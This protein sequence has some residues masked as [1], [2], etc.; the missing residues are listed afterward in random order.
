MKK[1]LSTLFIVFSFFAYAQV[2]LSVSAIEVDQPVTITIDANSTDS[3]CNGLNNP[4]KVYMHSGIG[5]NSDAFGYGVVGNWGFD[6]G[7]GEMTNN[8]DGT[9][10]ITITPQTYYGIT[11]A[12]ADTASQIGMVFRNEDGSQ[13]LKDDG[14]EDFIFPVGK[15]II[16]I[17]QP[18][19]E[20]V[21]LN[22][23]ND[24][25]LSATITF[26]GST[27]VQGS[28]EIFYNNV[29]VATGNCGFPACNATLTNVTESG[30]VKFV[31]TPPGSTETGEASFDV[32]VVPAVVEQALPANMIDGINYHTDPSK[33]TLVLTA[34]GK[35]FIQV[36]GS[37]NNYSPSASD[38]MKRDPSTG[39]YW[40]ELSGLTPGAIETYQYW[41]F[42]TNPVANSPSIVKVADP[43]SSLVL[44]P[45]DD[46]YIPASTYPNMPAYP[47]GQE[48]EVTVL[49]TGQTPYD[50]QVTDFEK[51][52]EEDLVIYEVLIRDF[53]A[54]RNFQDIIDK[55]D[56]FKNL[57]INAIELMPIMEFEGNESWGYNTAF[58][59]AI[60][61][62]YGTPEKFKELVD[63]CHQNGIAVI[64]DIAF[65]HAYGRN[66]MVRMWMDDPDGDGWGGPSSD[67]PYFNAF[68]MH[69]YSV[70][71]DF[72]HSSD[73]TRDYVKQVVSYWIEEYNIDGFRWDLTKGFTQNCGNGTLSG[74]EGCTGGYQQ[75]RVDVLKEYA[76]HSWSVDPDHYVIFEHL[77]SDNEEKEW[78]NYRLDEGKGIMMWGIMN[79][80]YGELTMGEDGNKNI[81]RMGHKAHGGFNGPRVV[82]YA[83]SHD[84]ERLMYKNIALGNT[85]NGS[86]N[87]Q[88]LNTALS[89]MSAL[90]AV[91]VMVPGPKMIWHFGELGME[92]SI[93][94]CPD[95][96]IENDGCKLATKPQP[97]WDNEWLTDALRGQI[98][99]DWSKLHKLKIEEPVFK[100]DYTITSG[101]LT[102]RIDIF[103]N[104]M[105]S[106]ELKNVI[107]LA[108]FD[109]VTR[110]IDTYF[111][112]GV[113]TTWYD[114][115]DAT[116]NTTVSN[117]TSAITIPA[118][119]FRILGNT[120]SEV[121]SV[122]DETM[123]GFS[124]YPN[125]SQSALSINVNVSNVEIYDLTGKLVKSFKGA[126]TRTDAFDIS[127]LNSGIYMVKV[128]NDTNQTLTSKLVKL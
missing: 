12:Q 65:N 124:I 60:D 91:S 18:T 63:I 42:D 114:L 31:G 13:E 117:S 101:N 53:D 27:T 88:D 15:V 85:S 82:G 72:N 28:F 93:F 34:P 95:G 109:V 10:S 19:N 45:F 62:F 84:E 81:D 86:H 54:D 69:S 9:F 17:T 73:Y 94:T 47:A 123:L 104:S 68:P 79:S 56:Y 37:W 64:L 6:D 92:N 59:M 111:P 110:S 113:T 90:G 97:Q 76:D 36:A 106:S 16:N 22:S 57:N 122:K 108:N 119:Q 52:V 125:P 74:D 29:S 23:G 100:G 33:A 71:N 30:T 14:C 46:A 50:W 112:A 41:V 75:D 89:R 51:P 44:S 98:Y 96:S 7:V 48:R 43:Y 21:V 40:L 24:L 55:I 102:P 128:Q 127:S 2:S 83:E 8:G 5:N 20:I 70:G 126:F 80:P 38:V 67:N 32:I 4:T 39:K 99:E 26:Q 105:P 25:S 118:G 78:A 103:D 77:G 107:I 35:E 1:T 49:Q 58:H 61:K 120:S 115:M 66:P 116:G 11:Q 87:V 3:N 121:L